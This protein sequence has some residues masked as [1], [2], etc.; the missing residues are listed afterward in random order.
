MEPKSCKL[1]YYHTSDR[2]LSG[3]LW[4]F[5]KY[6]NEHPVEE[7]KLRQWHEYEMKCTYEDIFRWVEV[8][9]TLSTDNN[10]EYP[11]DDCLQEELSSF[12]TD[13]EDMIYTENFRKF[14]IAHSNSPLEYT[15]THDLSIPDK[16]K[17][18]IIMRLLERSL[19]SCINIYDSFRS[20][21][22]KDR[23]PPLRGAVAT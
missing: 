16:R 10:T 11:F 14:M 4:V 21:P 9:I 8:H 2:V 3:W 19:N 13:N 22:A 23:K 20:S 17:P 7:A 6:Y 5:R 1:V 18:S 15:L 12:L